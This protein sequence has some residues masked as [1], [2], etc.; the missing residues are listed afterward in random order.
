MSNSRCGRA[1]HLLDDFGCSVM[2]KWGKVPDNQNRQG[3]GALHIIPAKHT[4]WIMKK[5][6]Y[7]KQFDFEQNTRLRIKKNH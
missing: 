4:F 7:Q 5:N 1:Q 3:R 6:N 2:S